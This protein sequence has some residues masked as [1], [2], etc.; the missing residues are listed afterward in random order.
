VL[1]WEVGYTT[2]PNACKQTSKHTTRYAAK[3]EC[4]R[5]CVCVCVCVGLACFFVLI[6][7]S[8]LRELS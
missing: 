3:I 6:K 2:P 5:V 8:Q 7:G 1:Q 4:V